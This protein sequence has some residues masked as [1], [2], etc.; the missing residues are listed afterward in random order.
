MSYNIAI[1]GPAGA[2]KSTVARITAERLNMT[3]IDTGAM[4][5]AFTLKA[6]A[7]NKNAISEITEMIK[8]THIE[9]KNHK[10]ILDGEDVTEKIRDTRISQKVSD[11]ARIP[12]VRFFMVHLQKKM[13]ENRGVVMDGRDIGTTVLPDAEYKFFL[14]A[15][16]R[17]RAIRRFEELKRRG[18]PAELSQIEK[19]IMERDL[20]D[21]RRECSPLVAAE[22]AVIIDTTHKSISEVVND[23]ISRVKRGE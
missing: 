23:I 5:R 19:D 16:L 9:V 11:I 2:G 10:I 8:D 3:Y 1:D 7:K 12:Q 6:L 13:A 18:Q 4:Y 15:Q 21:S 22:D 20:Q 14:T 17:Q